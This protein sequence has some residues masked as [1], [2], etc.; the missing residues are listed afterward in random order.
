[1]ADPVLHIKDGYFF[2]VPKSLWP[3]DYQS[4]D[5]VPEFI[6]EDHPHA[7][8][9]QISHEMSGKVLIPQ[10]FG[11]L[12]NLYEMK[13][14][15]GISRFMIIEL[16]I[17]G[18]LCAIFIPLARKYQTQGDRPRGRSWNLFESFLIY[19][20]NDVV[21]PAIAHDQHHFHEADRFLPLLWTMFFFILFCNLAGLVPWMGSP[22]GSF[23]VTT[24]M[25]L[26]TF[27]TV[28]LAG[29]IRL[30]PIGFWKNQV[31][32]M[33]L[34]LALAIILKPPIF[35]IE[36]VGMLIRHLVLAIRLLAN[37][38]AGHLVILG[39][40]GLI[41]AAA[42]ASENATYWVVVV[43]AVVG[44]TLLRCLELLVAFLQAYIFTFLSAL[45][46]GM[47]THHH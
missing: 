4:W 33:D 28:I 29:M 19:L 44:S 9:E 35:I 26:V 20:R 2:E 7:T 43:I 32:S 40:M 30:G 38:A 14:G 37:M 1:M 5:E 45:F 6:R 24:A 46:I 16:L 36:V 15:F 47:A 12:D 41:T 31:P 39:I 23:G 27:A 21:R 17:A 25:A 8:L 42:V 11:E 34:P 3:H 13:S 22:T 10:P 18:I